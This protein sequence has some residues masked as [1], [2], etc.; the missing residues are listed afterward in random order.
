MV[1]MSRTYVGK[2]VVTKIMNQWVSVV[3]VLAIIA[4]AVIVG[5]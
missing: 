5:N 4:T 3:P 2:W 1:Y